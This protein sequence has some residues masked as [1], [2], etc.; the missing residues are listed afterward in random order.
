MS[1]FT[2]G[3]D[4]ST[5]YDYWSNQSDMNDYHGKFALSYVCLYDPC[6]HGFDP[7]LSDT[8][9][10]GQFICNMTMLLSQWS[11]NPSANS[12]GAEAVES[13]LDVSINLG[14][15]GIITPPIATDEVDGLYLAATD[16]FIPYI[17]DREHPHVR[18]GNN[19]AFT[20]KMA[21]NIQIV[22]YDY[23]SGGETICILKTYA[24]RIFQR[25]CRNFLNK[26][27]L[28]LR[29]YGNPQAL[30]NREVNGPFVITSV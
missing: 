22:E 14:N 23:L 30:I 4:T 2:S 10:H 28:M 26:R 17:D 27:K 29:K 5:N 19:R 3:S 12:A 1:D 24:L 18:V 21:G 25:K 9:I 6:V 11:S 13:Y 20:A 16:Q 15:D 7:D 8:N